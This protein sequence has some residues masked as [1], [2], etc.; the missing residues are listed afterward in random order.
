MK[1]LPVTLAVLLL[2][3]GSKFGGT[4][5]PDLHSCIISERI[6]DASVGPAD[7]GGDDSRRLRHVDAQ[8]CSPTPSEKLDYSSPALRIPSRNLAIGPG[9]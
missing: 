3:S 7:D 8:T 5:P 1:S 4:Q 2:V 9:V 6:A